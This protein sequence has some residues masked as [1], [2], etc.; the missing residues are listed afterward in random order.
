M[1]I[2]VEFVFN[3]IG[4]DEDLATIGECY[5]LYRREMAL[6]F[7]PAVGM[8][9]SLSALIM[10]D[11]PRADEYSRLYQSVSLRPMSFTIEKITIL[12]GA[13]DEQSVL[14]KAQD[15]V[16]ND[17]EGFKNLERLLIDFYDFERIV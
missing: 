9:I 15:I 7:L 10:N 3:V 8:G 13:R 11:D 16:E 14:V 17:L 1:K 2:K 4:P 12:V 5:A 6:D